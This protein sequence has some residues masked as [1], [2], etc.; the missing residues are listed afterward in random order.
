MA[1][2]TFPTFC[3]VFCRWLLTTPPGEV[4]RAPR[5]ICHGSSSYSSYRHSPRTPPGRHSHT[6]RAP[7]TSCPG[8]GSAQ[9]T[10][11]QTGP[12]G[13]QQALGLNTI[14]LHL[15]CP[16]PP[17]PLLLPLV[18]LGA[19]SLYPPSHSGQTTLQATPSPRHL[20][21]RSPPGSPRGH[22]L[23]VR[24]PKYLSDPPL[25]P[26]WQALQSLAWISTKP[27]NLWPCLA[28]SLSS[29]KGPTARE[30]ILKCKSHPLAP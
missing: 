17:G 20:P 9:S 4:T 23:S 26:I 25:P 16:R 10:A 14:R 28:S 15:L 11:G 3:H 6:V 7:Q 24:P 30:K 18:A 21:P 27:P 13:A 8:P 22:H 5:W 1:V 29:A 2:G 12:C 19:L